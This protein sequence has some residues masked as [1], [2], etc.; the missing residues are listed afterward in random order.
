VQDFVKRS[1]VLSYSAARLEKQS[2]AIQIFAEREQLFAHAEAVR[3]RSA[4]KARA[5]LPPASVPGG[6]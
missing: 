5:P 4:V 3:A 1:S 6:R 2:R